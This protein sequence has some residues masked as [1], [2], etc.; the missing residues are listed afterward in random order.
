ML[1]KLRQTQDTS[2]SEGI[3]TLIALTF[4]DQSLCTNFVSYAIMCKGQAQ[5]LNLMWAILG[6]T[7]NFLPN[8]FTIKL[9]QQLTLL[10]KCDKISAL[11]KKDSN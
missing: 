4:Y 8:S 5:P 9:W 7:T 6:A 2:F 1:Y 10:G 11:N 3:S